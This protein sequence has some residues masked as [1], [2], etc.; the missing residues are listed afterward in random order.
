MVHLNV[1]EVPAGKS[2]TEVLKRLGL[3]I[4]I[5]VGPP[6]S[7][8][9]PVP[10]I[11]LLPLKANVPLLHCSI[12]EPAFDAVGKLSIKTVSTALIKLEQVVVPLV[13]ITV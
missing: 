7:L 8:Q 3:V 9:E 12:S 10:T 13:T 2:V 5:P 4:V 1:A 6:T 11:G